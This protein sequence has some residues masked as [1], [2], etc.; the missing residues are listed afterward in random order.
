MSSIIEYDDELYE[1]LDDFSDKIFIYNKEMYFT[2]ELDS[3]ELNK[4]LSELFKTHHDDEVKKLAIITHITHLI[5]TI[6]K[7]YCHE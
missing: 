4:V 2:I 7:N 1:D 6:K 3:A 5:Q